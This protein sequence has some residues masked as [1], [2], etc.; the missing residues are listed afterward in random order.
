MRPWMQRTPGPAWNRAAAHPDTARE[1]R[2]CSVHRLRCNVAARPETPVLWKLQQIFH[3]RIPLRVQCEF[4]SPRPPRVTCTWAGLARPYSTGCSPAIGAES[5]FCVSKIPTQN[6]I[7]LNWSKES[8]T[9][10]GGLVWIGM[11]DHFISRNVYQVTAPRPIDCS[12]VA[13]LTSATALPTVTRVGM[14][15]KIHPTMV[16][17]PKPAGGALCDALAAT[18]NLPLRAPSPQCDSGSLWKA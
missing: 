12:P 1:P 3:P 8:W 13:R 2:L 7:A 4:D 16:T 15:R 9:A 11:K 17:I 6:A 14:R 18:E 10:C 5:S